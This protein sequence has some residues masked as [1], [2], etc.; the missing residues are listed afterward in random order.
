MALVPRVFVGACTHAAMCPCPVVC[1]C[2]GWGLGRERSR[3]EEPQ[4]WGTR[5]EQTCVSQQRSLYPG[6]QSMS[7]VIPAGNASMPGQGLGAFPFL[8]SGQSGKPLG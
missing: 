8:T 3:A 5:L 2:V 7:P 6:L 4:S 1:A